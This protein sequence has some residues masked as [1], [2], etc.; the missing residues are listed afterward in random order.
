M[1][2]PSRLLALWFGL[3]AR[4][5][6]RAYAWTGFSLMTFKYSID[7]SVAWALTGELW[8]PFDYLT[9][10]LDAKPR[11][12]E[13]LW[14]LGFALWTLPFVWIGVSMTMRR[15]LDAGLSPWL[16]LL[17]FVPLV[18][19][20]LML[21][22]CAAPSIGGRAVPTPSGRGDRD[23]RATARAAGVGAAFGLVG[24]PVAIYAVESYGLLLFVGL[25][26]AIGF[27]SALSYNR[28]RPRSFADGAAAAQLAVLLTGGGLLLFGLE[29]L[30]C[31]VM[32]W[33]PAAVLA[34][35][36]GWLGYVI[37]LQQPARGTPLLMLA[38]YLPFLAGADL[39]RAPAPLREVRS[40]VEIDAP[41]EAVWPHVVGFSELPA[42]G[43]WVFAAGV[44]FPQRARIEGTGVGALRRCEFSTGPFVE[45]ITA[46]DAPHLLAFD[47]VAQ[48]EPMH[49]WSPY[50]R[51]NAPHLLEGFRAR[52]GE[53]RLE[54]LPGGRTR[55]EGSTWYTLEIFPQP[56]WTVW[57]DALIHTIHARVLEH[58]RTLS[59]H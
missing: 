42:P 22:L 29:G 58:V 1:S 6:A 56:Y 28:P 52:R 33:L 25:P 7:A 53:F 54:A 50:T 57:S 31:L 44:A 45:P 3:R 16:G 17:F 39:A 12:A 32:A 19:Y 26:F 10:L 20:A 4:V 30:L 14:L 2:R 27:A 11:P 21:L 5:D 18:N 55:L 34:A 8:T 43:R 46:W 15:S 59:E 23:W 48:P 35:L 38:V 24:A 37:A 51:V 9:P 13:D 41:P 40:S 49:E 36:G 47:V